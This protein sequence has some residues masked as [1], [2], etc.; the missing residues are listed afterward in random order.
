M[1]KEKKKGALSAPKNREKKSKG[2]KKISTRIAIIMGLVAV[3]FTAMMVADY[4]TMSRISELNTQ[5]SKYSVLKENMLDTSVAFQKIQLQANLCFY[6][7]ANAAFY[8]V[9]LESYVNNAAEKLDE[10]TTMNAEVDDAEITAAFDSWKAEADAYMEAARG[11]LKTAAEKGGGTALQSRIAVSAGALRKLDASE[12][13]LTNLIT[14]RYN[15]S[16]ARSEKRITITCYICEGAIV[17]AI[18]FAIAIFLYLRGIISKPLAKSAKEVNGIVNDL[19][20]GNGDLTKRLNVKN[21]EIGDMAIG[22]NTFIA[23]LQSVISD[24]KDKIAVLDTSSG[25]VDAETGKCVDKA[26]SV[27]AITEELSASMEEIAATLSDIA[28]GS[29]RVAEDVENMNAQAQNGAALAEDIKDRA[30]K[31][32]EETLENQNFMKEELEKVR[33]RLSAA[34]EE[35]RNVSK[36]NGLTEEILTIAGQTNLLSLNAS[37][38][39]ARAGDAGRGFGVV[40]DEIRNLADSSQKTAGNIQEI[41]ELVI[42]AVDK[43]SECAENIIKFMEEK[44]LGDYDGF[45]EATGRYYADADSVNEIVDKIAESVTAINETIQDMNNGIG[46]ISHAASQSAAGVTEVANN[47]GVLVESIE[48]IRTSAEENKSISDELGGQVQK[49]KNV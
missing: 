31:L 42:G 22:V 21:N 49:F 13:E 17:F 44:V 5:G 33:E 45:A 14:E 15:D 4:Y 37:I 29:E 18:I 7:S 28:K 12:T 25:K 20:E 3:V 16:L 6:D 1:S 36:I 34:L 19:K 26:N 47:V 8:A 11:I 10:V 39:A 35:S 40:A 38:E 30:S 48:T 46:D 24:L 2:K 32:K 41:S 9:Q 27:S 23:E 43:L